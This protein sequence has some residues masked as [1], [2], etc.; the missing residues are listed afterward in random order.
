LYFVVCEFNLYSYDALVCRKPSVAE[1]SKK[2]IKPGTTSQTVLKVIT[3]LIPPPV[4]LTGSM[5]LSPAEAWDH[6]QRATEFLEGLKNKETDQEGN[7]FPPL[8]LFS[9]VFFR[10]LMTFLIYSA[11]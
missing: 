6:C 5:M 8:L 10:W 11:G 9:F 1:P 3:A 2:T 7:H 4:G